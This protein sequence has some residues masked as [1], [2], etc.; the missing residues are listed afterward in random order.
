MVTLDKRAARQ[1]QPWVGSGQYF[2]YSAFHHVG[3]RGDALRL[4]TYPHLLR[5]HTSGQCPGHADMHRHRYALLPDQHFSQKKGLGRSPDS[6]P[7]HHFDKMSAICGRSMQIRDHAV[8]R[9]R[10]IQ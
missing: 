2:D 10:Q 7:R 4:S 9:N 1:F 3:I 8:R 6:A 5:R